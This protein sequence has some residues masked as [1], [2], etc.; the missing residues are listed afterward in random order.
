M[1]LE[2]KVTE[3]QHSTSMQGNRGPEGGFLFA[4]KW[5]R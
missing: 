1:N 2:V 5:E 4:L 3:K